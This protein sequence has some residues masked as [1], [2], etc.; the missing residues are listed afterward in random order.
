MSFDWENEKDSN[1]CDNAVSVDRFL[2]IEKMKIKIWSH[3]K[4]VI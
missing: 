2:R 4:S 3:D 1:T